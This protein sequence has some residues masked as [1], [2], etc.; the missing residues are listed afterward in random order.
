M[1]TTP[2]IVVKLDEDQSD[3]CMSELMGSQDTHPKAC[4]ISVNCTNI[5]T[6]PGLLGYGLTHQ[7]LWTMLAE[8][9]FI[10]NGIKNSLHVS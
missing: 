10:Y 1:I 2:L 9:V 7:L 8:K 6:T 5:M 4:D 3:V